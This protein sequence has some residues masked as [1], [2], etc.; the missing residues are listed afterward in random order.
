MKRINN[1][2]D[3]TITGIIN[4]KDFIF[5]TPVNHLCPDVHLIPRRF[6]ISIYSNFGLKREPID[7]IFFVSY[8]PNLNLSRASKLNMK[9]NF[10]SLSFQVSSISSLFTFYSLFMNRE[11]EKWISTLYCVHPKNV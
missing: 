5:F 11:N 8:Q 9:T 6:H 2:S 7:S 4:V 10:H 3:F 1:F